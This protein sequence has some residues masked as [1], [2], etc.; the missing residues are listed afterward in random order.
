[1]RTINEIAWDIKKDWKNINYSAK[2]YLEAMLQLSNINDSFYAD[3]AREVI[4]RFLVNAQT[5]RGPVAKQ[6]K[7]ELKN[8]LGTTR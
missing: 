4:L 8:L 6:I 2:P 5:W 7:F 1:M 3:S